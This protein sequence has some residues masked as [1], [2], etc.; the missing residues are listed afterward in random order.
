VLMRYQ[1]PKLPACPSCAQIMRLARVTQRFD[2]LP[3]LYAFECRA[4]GIAHIEAGC[5]VADLE[6]KNPATRVQT[7]ELEAHHCRWPV[8]GADA[9]TFFCGANK[10]GDSPYCARHY[11]MA[12]QPAGATRSRAEVETAFRRM[13]KMRKARAA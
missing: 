5:A 9:E 10:L 4:C 2:D 13:A 6:P 11:R 3:D 12:Y 1:R 7:H 8:D